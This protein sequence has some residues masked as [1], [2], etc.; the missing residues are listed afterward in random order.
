MGSGGTLVEILAMIDSGSNT[1]LLSKNA[2]E[3]LAITRTA[4]HLTMNLPG[5]ERRSGTVHCCLK[6]RDIRKT[7]E[8]YTRN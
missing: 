3:R 2:A 8:E 6:Y 4:T 5:G 1:S 7:L